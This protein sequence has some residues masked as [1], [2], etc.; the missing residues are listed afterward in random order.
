ML[1]SI[2]RFFADLLANWKIHR[3]VQAGRRIPNAERWRRSR[4][5]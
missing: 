2:L 3:D 4:H 1:A 5:G